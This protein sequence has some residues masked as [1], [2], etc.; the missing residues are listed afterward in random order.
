SQI[1]RYGKEN[2]EVAMGVAD[3]DFRVAPCVT[4]ALRSRC[5]H[6]NW[7]Y[8]IPTDSYKEA[9]VA[10]NKN[11]HGVEVDPDTVHLSS[12]V[13]PALIAALRA[14][15]PPGSQ[16]LMPTPI[17]SGFYSDLRETLTVTADSLGKLQNG[18]YSIDWDDL[19]SQMD[20][21]THALI[22]CNPQ[23]PTGNVWSEEE[24]LRLGRLCLERRI[25][26]LADEIHCDFVTKGQ[27]YV[28]FAGLPDKD[29]VNNSI[30]FKAISKTFSLAAMKSA[31]YFS[32]NQEF[33]DKVDFHHR[34]DLNTLGIIA[35]EAA[36]REGADWLDQLLPYLDGN[37]DFVESYARE[38]MPLVDYT[39]AQGTYLAWLDVSKLADKIDAKGKADAASESSERPVSPEVIVQR[40]FVDN[41]HV[42]MNP[43]S[44]YGTGG[45]GHMRMN[46]GTSRKLI[47]LAMD[48]MAAAMDKL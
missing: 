38:K 20:F 19:E 8:G 18:R 13:H 43:G 12:G 31:Y 48:N 33:L 16:V 40:W 7:G 34:A 42:Y 35:N 17:Y 24:L 29:V 36:Y 10:W 1:K 9:I 11:R 4:R 32:T 14:F 46:L 26:V 6:E 39:K 47:N 45:E 15:S 37:H 44:N 41:A 28:P 3:M 2:I 23:N 27:K 22:L 5:D 30:S 21:D 25:V